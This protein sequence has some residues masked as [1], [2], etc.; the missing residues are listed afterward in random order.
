MKS[1]GNADD[2][3]SPYFEPLLTEA[4]T[5]YEQ[6]DIV[7]ADAAYLSRDNCDLVAELGAIPRIY[8]PKQGVTL[9]I[10]RSSALAVCS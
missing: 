2:N 8:H 7:S 9:K 4:V 6:I 3:E 5:C 1:S 10:R